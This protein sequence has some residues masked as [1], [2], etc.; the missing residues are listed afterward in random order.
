MMKFFRS[1]AFACWGFHYVQA[2]VAE[3]SGFELSK[4]AGVHLFFE[5]KD[6]VALPLIRSFYK[7]LEN[8]FVFMRQRAE[9]FLDYV[10]VLSITEIVRS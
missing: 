4:D 3:C 7:R 9:Q 5:I 1:P 10:G 6:L 8:V 2:A